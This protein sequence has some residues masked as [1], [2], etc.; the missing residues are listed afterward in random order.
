MPPEYT[1]GLAK[2]YKRDFIVSPAVLIPRIETEEIIEQV[3]ANAKLIADVGTGSGCLGI[4]LAEK[5][6]AA[7]VY[8]SDISNEALSIARQ[9]IQTK[10]VIILKSNLLS[11]YPV[12]L[13]FDVIVANLPYIPSKRISRL[14]AA[15][16]K[17]E[18]HL[19]LDGGPD[20]ATLINQ[21]I[22]QLPTRLKPGGL[23]VLEIDDTHTLKVFDL[24]E[25]FSGEI[26]KDRFERNRFIILKR[27]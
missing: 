2:F 1:R 7:T 24:P 9:N 6:P 18:P 3:P 5:Y 15:I 4:S 21:L 16:R 26:K 12:N 20:G 13:L 11:G 23:A 19:A 17:Y 22:K 10:N 27:S 25:S 14:L 8:I